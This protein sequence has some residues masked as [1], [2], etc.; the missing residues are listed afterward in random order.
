M[1]S[2]DMWG[3]AICFLFFVSVCHSFS[4]I[5]SLSFSTT[6]PAYSIALMSSRCVA[7]AWRGVRRRGARRATEGERVWHRGR[8]AR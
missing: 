6:E 7:A 4:S 5:Q 3:V 1:S 2:N 8:C